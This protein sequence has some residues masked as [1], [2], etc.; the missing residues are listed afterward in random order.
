MEELNIAKLALLKCAQLEMY[1]AEIH[2]ANDSKNISKKSKL[3][4]LNPV[5]GPDGLLRVGS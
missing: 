3:L 2:C 1:P 5:L 4:S